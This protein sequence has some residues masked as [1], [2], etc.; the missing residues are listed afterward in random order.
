MELAALVDL[1]CEAWSE[2]DAN[3]RAELLSAVWAEGATYSDP[4]VY[5]TGG[6]DELLA[7]IE[8]VRGTLPGLRIVRTSAIDQHHDSARFHWDLISN[9]NAV[10]PEGLDLVLLS[11][12]GTKLQRVVG[13]FGPLKALNS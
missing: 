11:P 12:D 4:T 5:L 7:H 9:G 1:Y 6:A 2:P 10:V 3:R 13:F 8:K